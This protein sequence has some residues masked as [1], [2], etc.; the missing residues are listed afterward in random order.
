M[1]F[2]A[3][4][5]LLVDSMGMKPCYDKQVLERHAAIVSTEGALIFSLQG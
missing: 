4:C 3:G 5:K 2:M 1:F